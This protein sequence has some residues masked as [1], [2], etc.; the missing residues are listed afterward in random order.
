MHGLPERKHQHAR[1][2]RLQLRRWLG[3]LWQR[4]RAYV[5]DLQSRVCLRPV[6]TSPMPHSGHARSMRRWHLQPV[7]IALPEYVG[8]TALTREPT[9]SWS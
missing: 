8:R 1:L 3:R 9:G 5:A 2:I 4:L 7:G 6:L